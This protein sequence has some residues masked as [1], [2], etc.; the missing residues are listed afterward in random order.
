MHSVNVSF[1]ELSRVLVFLDSAMGEIPK[2]NWHGQ[3]KKD[4]QTLQSQIRMGGIKNLTPKCPVCES[5]L[6]ARDGLY[7]T[8]LTCP[9]GT[10]AK[11]HGS[12]SSKNGKIS[13]KPPLREALEYQVR[14]G[15]YMS[16]DH[17]MELV[18]GK[19]PAPA[20]KSVE[21][22]LRSILDP[23]KH[24]ADFDDYNPNNMDLPW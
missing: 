5:L 21:T 6:I 9:K 15:K 24:H 10:S 2:P 23:R 16:G 3:A 1:E 18:I 8:F 22:A 13:G 19:N 20:P 17:I 7:G 14:S 4:I 11:P 12:F